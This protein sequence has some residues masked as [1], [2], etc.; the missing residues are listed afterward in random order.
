MISFYDPAFF[1]FFLFPGNT[2]KKKKK[3]H[4]TATLPGGIRYKIQN[5]LSVTTGNKDD[6]LEGQSQPPTAALSPPLGAGSAG[7]R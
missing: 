4:P 2:K 6:G 5:N 3:A 1:F 7:R